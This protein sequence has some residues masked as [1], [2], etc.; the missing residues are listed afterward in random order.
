MIM[1]CICFYYQVTILLNER[2][3]M[4]TK[5]LLL[6]AVI[7]VSLLTACGIIKESIEIPY[8]T[9]YVVKTERLDKYNSL[10]W[11][12]NDQSI[13]SVSN[14]EINGVAPGSTLIIAKDG[15]TVVAQYS[16][17]I[18]TIPVTSIVLSTN[19]TQISEGEKYQLSY[20][21]FPENASDYGLT[22]KSA[23][24]RVAT[25]DSTGNITAVSVGQTTI[26]ISNRDGFI[27]TCSVTV[28]K[29]KPN[30][31]AIYKEYCDSTWAS[32][33][34]DGSYLKIDTNPNNIDDYFDYD[35]YKAVILV[36]DA[37]G[38]PESL[39]EKMGSTRA[40][41]GTQ[42]QRYENITVTWTYHPD[43]GLEVIYEVN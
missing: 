20:T 19:S 24:N 11:T 32:V 29:A 21:L 2:H 42:V 13:A 17:T 39:L 9:P 12:S 41:D 28:T 14:G 37:L 34:K 18:V 26:S 10:S 43:N 30:F 27:A 1:A 23:D 15:K 7:V 33:S 8:G 16:V 22:W 6:C 25:V 35:A 4:K 36:N 40:L 3:A 31:I 38:L 5:F